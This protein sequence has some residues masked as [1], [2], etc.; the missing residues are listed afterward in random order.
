MQNIIVMNI[1]ADIK[2]ISEE[3]KTVKDPTLIEAF[4]IC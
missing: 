1:E 2:W 3:L 4:K